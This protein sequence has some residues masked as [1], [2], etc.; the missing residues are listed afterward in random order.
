MRRTSNCNKHHIHRFFSLPYFDIK[1]GK[2]FQWIEHHPLKTLVILFFCFTVLKI[3]LSQVIIDPSASFDDYSYSKM[4]QSVWSDQRFLING[5]PSHKYPPV[6]PFLLSPS[7]VLSDSIDITRWMR[8]CNTLLS[9]LILFPAFFLSKEFLNTKKSLF[10]SMLISAMAGSF[11]FIFQIYSENLY[12]VLL[13][14]T[15]FLL[16]KSLLEQGYKYKILSGLFMGICFLTKYTTG[17]LVIACFFVFII[18]EIFRTEKTKL[19]AVL[20]GIKKYVLVLFFAGLTIAP[21]MLRNSIHFG[22]TFGGMLGYTNWLTSSSSK[23]VEIAQGT[24]SQNYAIT[25]ITQFVTNNAFLIL[26]SG[27]VFFGFFLVFF[28]NALRKRK[29]KEMAI[30]ILIMIAL[31]AYVVL[32]SWHGLRHPWYLNGRYCEPFLTLL[33]M[34]GYVSIMKYKYFFTYP[35]RILWLSLPVFFL[36][37]LDLSTTAI[38]KTASISY[39]IALLKSKQVCIAAGLQPIVTSTVVIQVLSALFLSGILLVILFLLRKNNRK[40]VLIFCCF[41]IVLSSALACTENV[42]IDTYS[43]QTEISEMGSFLNDKYSGRKNLIVFD[44]ATFSDRHDFVAQRT[45]GSW[46]NTPIRIGKI[47]KYSTEKNVVLITSTKQKYPLVDTFTISK[48]F[49]CLSLDENW[50]KTLFVYYLGDSYI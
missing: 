38:L 6:Y 9:S 2:M 36:V 50:S 45:L 31:E 40:K 1:K 11:S 10:I 48:P 42:L 20:L 37:N 47:K 29:E 27:I 43:I 44:N 8:I 7:Y 5:E 15:I 46:L 25:F 49:A 22:F 39:L 32:T 17:A 16:Y 21:W 3:L 18:F 4:A 41:L 30:G 26:G 13:L 24:S 12:Q 33:V 35:F 34:F 23:V 14:L 28:V 19:H